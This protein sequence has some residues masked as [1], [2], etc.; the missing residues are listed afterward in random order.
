MNTQLN[1]RIEA[2][3]EAQRISDLEVEQRN[4]ELASQAEELL[5]EMMA[6]YGVDEVLLV[7]LCPD[8]CFDDEEDFFDGE[9]FGNSEYYAQYTI[10]ELQ[11]G[12]TIKEGRDEKTPVITRLGLKDG[13]IVY[14]SAIF[15]YSDHGDLYLTD[16]GPE[17]S[18]EPWLPLSEFGDAERRQNIILKCVSHPGYWELMRKYPELCF[19]HRDQ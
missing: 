8:G 17:D 7:P 10:K 5:K 2:F 1:K 18:Q 13:T 9:D 12:K 14:H 11:C 19:L 6:H 16:I 15:T 4:K 3:K